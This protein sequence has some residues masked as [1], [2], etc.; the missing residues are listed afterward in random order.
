MKRGTV[1][2]AAVGL[3]TGSMLFWWAAFAG[4]GF[5]FVRR[6]NLPW[7]AAAIVAVPANWVADRA[8]FWLVERG[9]PGAWA[10]GLRLAASAARFHG[11]GGI[12]AVPLL[13]SLGGGLVGW[14]ASRQTGGR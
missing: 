7:W 14:Y 13:L 5:W 11:F 10:D 1:L 8:L 6:T 2:A 12:V 3:Y 4:V 9:G